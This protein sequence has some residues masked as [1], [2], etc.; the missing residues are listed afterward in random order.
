MMSD[1][2]GQALAREGDAGAKGKIMMSDNRGQALALVMILTA[3]IFAMGAAS[4][5]LATSLR[6]NAGLEICQK[7]AYYTAE[8]GIDKAI[9]LIKSGELQ[10]D[11]LDDLEPEQKIDLVP[12]LISSEYADGMIDYV[13]VSKESCGET[14]KFTIFVESLGVCQGAF[15][16]LQAAINVNMSLDFGKGLWISSPIEKP[17]LIAPSARIISQLYIGGPLH[18][19][20]TMIDGDI[21]YDGEL[22]VA[23]HVQLNGD[24]IN[25]NIKGHGL[26]AVGSGSQVIGDVEVEGDVILSGEA[27]VDGDIKAAGNVTVEKAHVKGSIWSNGDILVDQ[28]SQVEGDI[29]SGQQNEFNAVFPPFP[30]VDLFS[31]RRGADQLLEGLQ[32]LQGSLH[33]AGLAFI[34]GDLEIEGAYTGTGVI[35]VDGTVTV[36]GDLLPAG[37]HDSLCIM[38]AEPVAVADRTQAAAL[39][40]GQEEISLGEGVS[41]QGSVITPSLQM[42][43]NTEFIYQNSLVEQ[44]PASCFITVR[45]LSWERG[46]Q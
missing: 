7:K 26:L 32:Q 6:R 20:A 1:N 25:G 35:V 42:G 4:L 11:E 40:Y 37:Q 24:I 44:F 30:E 36:T 41:L 17:S 46:Y 45:V 16:I 3:F 12:D 9:A 10:L 22:I 29:Y 27:T 39:I 34:D 8:A 31:Y 2:R 23:D 18:L 13:K 14:K 21:F 38:A 5:S 15:C 28:D 43:K 19:A 33:L